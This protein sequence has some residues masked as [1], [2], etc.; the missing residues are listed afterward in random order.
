MTIHNYEQL[1]ARA[2]GG[3]LSDEESR[4]LQSHTDTCAKCKSD[5]TEFRE[6]VRFALP[7]APSRLRRSIDMIR[8]RPD[9][10]ARERFIRR[11]ALEGIVFS[12]EVKGSDRFR[13]SRLSF[14]AATA[15]GALA[16]IVIAFLYGSHH[17]GPHPLQSDQKNSTQAQQRLDHLGQQNPT[18][19][20]TISQLQHALAEQQRET[21]GLRTQAATLTAAANDHRRDTEQAQAE[22]T[23]SASRNAQ[24]LEEAATQQKVQEKLLADTRAELARLNQ[25]RASDQA[26]IV[27]DQVHINELSEQL[28]QPERMSTW[29]GNSRHQVRMFAI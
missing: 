21:E 23:Q 17:A 18:L 15:A 13:R 16:A 5:A 7:L 8:N 20:L 27:A 19:D 1:A 6:L 28:K 11:A 29:S 26:S 24:S 22:A 10:G 4:D 2:A 12:Q 9:P 25:A 14:V 3:Y